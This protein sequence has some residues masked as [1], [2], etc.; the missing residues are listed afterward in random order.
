MP[1]TH[2]RP[3]RNWK[4]SSLDDCWMLMSLPQVPPP[5]PH[6]KY[7][8]TTNT[9]TNCSGSHQNPDAL[10]H[11]MLHAIILVNGTKVVLF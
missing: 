7:S 10:V 3:H 9:L 2:L 8:K 11:G 5:Q 1:G 6:S 4:S